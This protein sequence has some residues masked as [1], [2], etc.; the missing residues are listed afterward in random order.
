MHCAVATPKI[1][2]NKS[3]PFSFGVISISERKHHSVIVHNLFLEK[4]LSIH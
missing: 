3:T 2:P 4:C 1:N